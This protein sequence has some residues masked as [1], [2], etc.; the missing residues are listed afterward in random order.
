MSDPL[1]TLRAR[2]AYS[3]NM[4]AFFKRGLDKKTVSPWGY[5]EYGASDENARLQPA[6]EALL[7]VAEA[8]DNVDSMVTL[9]KKSN[10]KNSNLLFDLDDAHKR[11]SKALR[12]LE[13]VIEDQYD[14][15]QTPAPASDKKS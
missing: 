3:E 15:S 13:K 8:A 4:P 12:G 11:L 1:A 7:R 6:I 5:Y 10:G 2:L 9:I 14:A